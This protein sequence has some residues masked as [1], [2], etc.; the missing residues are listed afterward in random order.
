M[1]KRFTPIRL[2]SVVNR[3]RVDGTPWEDITADGVATLPVGSQT[4]WG[5]PF[6]F[7]TPNHLR[8]DDLVVVGQDDSLEHVEIQIGLTV[9][10]LVVAHFCDTRARSSAAGQTSDYESGFTVTAPG[11]HLADYVTVHKSGRRQRRPIRRRFEVNQIHGSSFGRSAFMA[12]QH[13]TPQALELHGP[14]EAHMW[15]L[16]QTGASIGP[17][18]DDLS[19]L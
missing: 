9:S 8:D 16:H 13:L 17:P 18:S 10:F 12:R 5:V 15:G 2:D 1:A 11:E 6:E 4:F 19:S 7:I 3:A 14:Y